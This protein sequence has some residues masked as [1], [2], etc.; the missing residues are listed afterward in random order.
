M[1][2]L[3]VLPNPYQADDNDGDS[4]SGQALYPSTAPTN[5]MLLPLSPLFGDIAPHPKATQ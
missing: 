5:L 3:P 1:K 4:C 2:S